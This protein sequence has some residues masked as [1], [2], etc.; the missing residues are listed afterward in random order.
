L[1]ELTQFLK[2][3]KSHDNLLQTH[4]DHAQPS[5]WEKFTKKSPHSI[6]ELLIISMARYYYWK[7]LLLE[8]IFLALMLY[9]LNG[10]ILG[11]PNSFPRNTRFPQLSI[12]NLHLVLI[13]IGCAIME[14]QSCLYNAHKTLYKISYSIWGAP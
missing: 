4:R 12:T 14:H 3:A 1:E 8:M 11:L 10:H 13:T 7:F 6:V 5:H 2:I 9:L